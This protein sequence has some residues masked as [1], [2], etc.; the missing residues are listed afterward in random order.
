MMFARGLGNPK[1]WLFSPGRTADLLRLTF[2]QA[3]GYDDPEWFRA[4]ENNIPQ[5]YV[6]N[7]TDGKVVASLAFL[8][9]R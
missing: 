5:N 6:R 2:L 7:R 9:F 3:H 4:F 1:A 8:L